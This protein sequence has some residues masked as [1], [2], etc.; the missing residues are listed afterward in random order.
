MANCEARYWVRLRDRTV[1]L[2]T[3]SATK[4]VGETKPNKL[5]IKITRNCMTS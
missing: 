1:L 5:D 2:V 3:F 4:P